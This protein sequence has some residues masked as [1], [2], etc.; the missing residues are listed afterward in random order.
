VNQPT[1]FEVCLDIVATPPR[2]LSDAELLED[3]LAS[4]GVEPTKPLVLSLERLVSRLSYKLA[5]EA[6]R[7]WLLSLPRTSAAAAALRRVLLHARDESAREAGR[8]AG[9]S[10]TAILKAERRLE[11]QLRFPAKVTCRNE[12]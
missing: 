4:Y 7:H 5:G 2:E 10:H 1:Q 8:R 12:L 9:V 6:V 11:R 3:L